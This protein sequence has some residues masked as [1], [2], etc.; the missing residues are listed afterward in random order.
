MGL[1]AGI[2]N[3]TNYMIIIGCQSLWNLT[4]SVVA[5]IFMR[6]FGFT[7]ITKR[8]RRIFAD[9]YAHTHAFTHTNVNTSP[10]VCQ[11][12]C[13]SVYQCVIMFVG[14]RVSKR[15]VGE[16]DRERKKRV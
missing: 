2:T 3:S 15:E 12:V 7:K 9:R 11:S 5:D 4:C 16:R 14:L 13:A 8:G 6:D 1:F 10:S